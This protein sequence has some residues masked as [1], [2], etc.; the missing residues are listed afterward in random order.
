MAEAGPVKIHNDMGLEKISIGAKAFQC[1]GAKAP[2]D[3]PHVFLD[4]GDDDERVCPYCSTL[5]VY[6][7]SLVHDEAIPAEAVYREDA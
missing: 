5:F 1:T 3:H 2:F 4:M 7:G 6:D